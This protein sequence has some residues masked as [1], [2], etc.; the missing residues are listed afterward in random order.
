M[1]EGKTWKEMF[2]GKC[3]NE[4]LAWDDT[5]R[6]CAHFQINGDCF[7]DCQNAASHV[8]ENKIPQKKKKEFVTIMESAC[9]S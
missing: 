5:S 1:K 7:E 8:P 6:M 2:C 3:A 9:N 4:R